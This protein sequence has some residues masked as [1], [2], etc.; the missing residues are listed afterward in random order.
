MSQPTALAMHNLRDN[1]PPPLTG[2]INLKQTKTKMSNLIIQ[3]DDE[4]FAALVK[5]TNKEKPKQE[6]LEALREFLRTRPHI[7]KNVGNLSRNVENRLFESSGFQ[8][9][10][11]TLKVG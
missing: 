3:T 5:A 7:W 9:E 10:C 8:Q 1:L 11:L 6:D 4:H 2:L